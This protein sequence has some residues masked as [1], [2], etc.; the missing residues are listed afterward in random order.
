MTSMIPSEGQWALAVVEGQQ[1]VPFLTLRTHAPHRPFRKA[2]GL[3]S[4][5]NTGRGVCHSSEA[6]PGRRDWHRSCQCSNAHLLGHSPNALPGAFLPR[7]GAAVI[8]GLLPLGWAK[9]NGGNDA[10]TAMPHWKADAVSAEPLTPL[11][12]NTVYP[13]CPDVCGRTASGRTGRH[14]LD[15]TSNKFGEVGSAAAAASMASGATRSVRLAASCRALR[16][17]AEQLGRQ[18]RALEQ[19]AAAEAA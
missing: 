1:T 12:S 8:G 11:F 9:T 13:C 16:Q 5:P 10:A 18:S 15:Q 3:S 6:S 19:R 7:L 4:E 14:I 2:R 17:G